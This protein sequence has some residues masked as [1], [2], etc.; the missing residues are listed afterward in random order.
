MS[1][2][3]WNLSAS[4]NRPAFDSTVHFSY[5]F[6]AIKN[7]AIG[8]KGNRLHSFTA[9]G[10]SI[11]SLVLP[12]EVQDSRNM[13]IQFGA[14]SE[15]YLSSAD[16]IVRLVRYTAAAGTL[17]CRI[18]SFR[19]HVTTLNVV[20]KKAPKQI[21]VNGRRLRAATSIRNSDGTVSSDIVFDAGKTSDTI[22]V[23]W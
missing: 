6:G 11:P 1:D 14:F 9:D 8:G 12:L 19:G 18:S 7:A 16:A 4:G 10:K 17:E 15:P 13:S 3:V 21:L 23:K 5:T 22:T 20:S 2:H